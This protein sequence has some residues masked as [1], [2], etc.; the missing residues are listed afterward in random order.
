[1]SN[2][3]RKPQKHY[4]VTIAREG[5]RKL[6]ICS[7]SGG[8]ST[9][10]GAKEAEIKE[11]KEKISF[12]LETIGGLLNDIRGAKEQQSRMRLYCEINGFLNEIEKAKKEEA[13]VRTLEL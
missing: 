8:Y 10:A 9:V 12:H 11:I 6:S 5:S 13:E 7:P 4:C 3:S 2:S 1:M